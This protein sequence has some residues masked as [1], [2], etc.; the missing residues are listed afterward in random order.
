MPKNVPAAPIIIPLKIKIFLILLSV[1]PMAF[2]MAISF[3]FSITIIISV[4]AILKAATRT[5]SVNMINI[6][7]FSSLRA[8]NRFLFISIQSLAK[9]YLFSCL[10]SREETMLSAILFASYMLS[11]RTPIPVMESSKRMIFCASLKFI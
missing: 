5:I 7:F 4:L 8:E 3:V 2:N 10:L 11:T 1:A 6:A 9:K